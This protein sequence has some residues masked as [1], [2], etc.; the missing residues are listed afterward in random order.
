MQAP[1]RKDN[2]R[3][4]QF[5]PVAMIAVTVA[6]AALLQNTEP[7]IEHQVADRFIPAVDV[8]RAQ[9]ATETLRIHSH[10]I[11]KPATEIQL[12]S[13]VA[14]Q[15]TAI[16]PAFVA[17]G[18]FAK[19][20]VLL[21]TDSALLD[22]E[23]QK[24][25]ASLARARLQEMEIRADIEAR[26]SADENRELSELAQGKPRLQAARANTR[27][28]EAAE[29]QARRQRQQAALKAPFDG[30]VMT[31]TIELHEQL[32]PGAPIGRIYATDAYTV[33]L[34]VTPGQLA[35][36]ASA[37]DGQPGS[38]VKITDPANGL[39]WQGHIQRAEGHIE[40]NRLTYLI[41]KLDP[42]DIP[43]EKHRH[44]LPG[45]LVNAEIHSK[46]LDNIITLP[47]SALQA[48]NTVYLLDDDNR[49][50]I[51]PVE[52]LYRS[53]DTIYLSHGLQPGERV[54]SSHIAAATE[55]I[56]LR[57]AETSAG[58]EPPAR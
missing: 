33:R 58:Q 7:A 51:R 48:G 26:S 22:M 24:A 11:L 17:G 46:P 15:V 19:G 49:L 57:P 12:L 20:D 56:E 4:K 14:G 38:A 39:Q 41:A 35:L 1:T 50:E 28:A 55:G 2:N 18:E 42:A 21:E 52:L 25:R 10:G 29:Q 3:L 5:A 13:R 9:A 36:V 45:S 47:A 40:R 27:A 34:P 6:L 32:S 31:R 54:I 37:S 30:K 23:L 44:I 8:I 16:N 53:P 43:A